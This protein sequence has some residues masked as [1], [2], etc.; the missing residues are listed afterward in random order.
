[1]KYLIY[2]I[3]VFS[4]Q[5]KTIE[6][7]MIQFDNQ[8]HKYM[9]ELLEEALKLKGYTLVVKP[10]KSVPQS[11]ID[12]M[13]KTGALD[14]HWYLKDKH[15]DNML[16]PVNVGLTNGLIGKRILFIRREDQEK[17]NKIKT[18]NDLRNSSLVGAFGKGWYDVK[19]WN[20]NK[21]KYYEQDGDWTK[22]FKMIQSGERKIDYLSRGVNEI[23]F[24]YPSVQD[25]VEIEKNLLLNYDSDFIFYLNKDKSREREIIEEALNLA[26]NRRLI[27]KLVKKYYAKDLEKLNFNKRIV[28]DLETP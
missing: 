14:I 15:G 7:R 23:L 12:F 25:L 22:L 27:E 6:L 9:Q 17:F 21:L 24:E 26:K 10:I 4:I 1:M 8:T 28:I 18:L 13:L 5:A 20:Y 16:L 2:F 19:I 11:R 3:F